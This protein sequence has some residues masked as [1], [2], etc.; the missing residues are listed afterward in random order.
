M[1]NRS[2]IHTM[3]VELHYKLHS[4]LMP[5]ICTK[6]VNVFTSV[7]NINLMGWGEVLIW[8]NTLVSVHFQKCWPNRYHFYGKFRIWKKLM[9]TLFEGNMLY[10]LSNMWY[11]KPMSIHNAQCINWS[12]SIQMFQVYKLYEC[13][14][15]IVSFLVSIH[16]QHYHYNR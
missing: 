12:I 15:K 4:K 1:C 2:A 14:S 11:S 13:G 3:T 7:Q 10:V 5:V 8:G 9:C 6:N 16:I